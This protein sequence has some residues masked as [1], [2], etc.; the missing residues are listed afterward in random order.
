MAKA[1]NVVMLLMLVGGLCALASA[2]DEELAAWLDHKITY[3]NNNN[4]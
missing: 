4:N 2:T 1:V 3:R